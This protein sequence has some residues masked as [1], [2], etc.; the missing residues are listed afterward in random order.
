MGIGKKIKKATK[1][2][3]KT[4]TSVAKKVAKSPLFTAALSVVPGGALVGQA[5]QVAS[6]FSERKKLSELPPIEQAQVA[7][8][9]QQIESASNV[10]EFQPNAPPPDIRQPVATITQLMAPDPPTQLP[11]PPYAQI[12]SVPS[13]YPHEMNQSPEMVNGRYDPYILGDGKQDMS[14]ATF[15]WADA[16]IAMHDLD[17]F[18]VLA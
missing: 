5:I 15:T 6:A 7:Q 8:A 18:P 10:A 14:D 13:N 16:M 3:T 1:K 4:I 2:Y 17:N 11:L 12:E 9:V